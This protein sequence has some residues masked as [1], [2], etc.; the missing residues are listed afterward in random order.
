MKTPAPA[1]QGQ[2]DY[3]EKKKAFREGMSKTAASL[4][5]RKIIAER[6]KSRRKKAEEPITDRQKYFLKGC[7]IETEGMSKLDATQEIAKIKQK[8]G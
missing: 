4:Q 2:R 1:T 7:G 8:A 5:I 6:N 3:L